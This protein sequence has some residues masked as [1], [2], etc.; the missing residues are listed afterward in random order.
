MQ[1]LIFLLLALISFESYAGC[2]LADLFFKKNQIATGINS[3]HIC[4]VRHN[5]DESQMKL[6]KAYT[7]GDYGLARDSRQA[8]YFFQLSAENGNAEAQ[9]SLAQLLMKSDEKPETRDALLNYRSKLQPTALNGDKS[10]FNGDFMHPYALLMLA[11]E[12]PDKKWYYPSKVR[13]APAK[14]VTLYKT[15]KIDADKKRLAMRQASQ[16][17]TRKLLQV[18]KEIYPDEEYP[19]IANRLKNSQTQKQAL[20]ELKQKMEAYIQEQNEIRKAK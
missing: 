3:L 20:A 18:A 13:N 19:D 5:D 1:K 12:S 9:L 4:A 8:L 15:Y 2:P 16:F 14:A 17:K 10:N 7:K 6:A 11:S